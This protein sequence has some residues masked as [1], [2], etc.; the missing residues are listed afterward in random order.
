MTDPSPRTEGAERATTPEEVAPGLM[1]IGAV[2]DR[3][4]MSIR[5]LRHYDEVGL[6]PP[7][8][9]SA[10]GFR[11]YTEADVDRIRTIRRMK[12]LGFSLEEMR[13]LLEAVDLLST[14]G[15]DHDAAR[16]TVDRFHR[17]AVANY[18]RLQLHLRYAAEFV[19]LLDGIRLRD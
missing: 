17:Q 7:S 18:E 3:T 11:L 8:A 9:R 16:Q 4:E 10:G 14:P 5:T 2:A 12:P 1:H 15:A 13:Q 6:V 19:G